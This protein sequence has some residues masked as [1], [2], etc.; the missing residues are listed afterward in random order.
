MYLKIDWDSHLL[1]G[2]NTAVG[3]WIPVRGASSQKFSVGFLDS[4][5]ELLNG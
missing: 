4:A 3:V 5:A 1:A 2:A